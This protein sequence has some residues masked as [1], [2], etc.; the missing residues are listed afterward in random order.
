METVEYQVWAADITLALMIEEKEDS[1]NE[2]D[3][4]NDDSDNG[5]IDKEDDKHNN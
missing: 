2:F 1:K 4:G 3:R 5:E